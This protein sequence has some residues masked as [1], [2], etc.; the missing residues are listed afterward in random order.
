MGRIHALR[1]PPVAGLVVC[2]LLLGGGCGQEHGG[3]IA[4]LREGTA[5]QRTDAAAF[6]GAQRVSSAVPALRIALRDTVDEVRVKAVWALG[7]LRSKEALSDLMLMLR[8]GNRRVRQ[9]TAWTL[10]QIEE[11]EAIPA[12]EVAFRV[13]KDSW[14]QEDLKRAIEYLKQFQGEA[15]VGESRF[16]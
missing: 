16:R 14:V 8:D 12:L 3:Y 4:Q 10:T 7:M 11:P 6:L 2:I 9:T 5:E 1:V 15:E 13:E